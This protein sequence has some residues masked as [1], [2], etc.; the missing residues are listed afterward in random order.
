MFSTEPQR[1]SVERGRRIPDWVFKLSLYWNHIEGLLCYTP[2]F[3]QP[4]DKISEECRTGEQIQC[5]LHRVILTQ[6]ELFSTHTWLYSG[7]YISLTF[8]QEKSFLRLSCIDQNN[9]WLLEETWSCEPLPFTLTFLLLHLGMQTLP[10]TETPVYALRDGGRPSDRTDAVPAGAGCCPITGTGA[11]WAAPLRRCGTEP[12]RCPS[13]ANVSGHTAIRLS[14]C[15]P[16]DDQT[17]SFRHTNSVHDLTKVC[18][19]PV[20]TPVQRRKITVCSKLQGGKNSLTSALF[21]MSHLWAEQVFNYLQQ[22]HSRTGLIA[23]GV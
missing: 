1:A 11:P 9:R 21:A 20:A 19:F 16:G 7:K 2:K 17:F 12:A 5:S 4:A 6:L 10:P 8:P 22:A 14:H 18:A 23:A 13:H 3:Y 15:L